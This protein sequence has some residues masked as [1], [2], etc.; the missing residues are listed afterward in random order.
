MDGNTL[1]TYDTNLKAFFHSS[2]L[3]REDI[4]VVFNHHLPCARVGSHDVLKGQI[5]PSS[6]PKCRLDERRVVGQ[7]NP[8]VVPCDACG[9]VWP[10]RVANTE[11]VRLVASQCGGGIRPGEYR[12]H[13]CVE[14][15][16]CEVKHRWQ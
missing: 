8:I 6:Q 7:S 13:H 11:L 10:A 14:Q 9:L 16:G 1:L 4:H 5:C 2:D 3:L 12:W 15:C